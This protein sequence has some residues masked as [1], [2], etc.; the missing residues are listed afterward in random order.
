LSSPLGRLDL[1]RKSA[2][3]PVAQVCA[4][5]PK[6]HRALGPLLTGSFQNRPR[7]RV[8]PGLYLLR[9]GDFGVHVPVFLA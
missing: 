5:L 4:G 6:G 8:E 7:S 1:G 3:L 9:R 2:P